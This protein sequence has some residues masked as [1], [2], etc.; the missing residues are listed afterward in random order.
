MA[1]VGAGL[2]AIGAPIARAE[3]SNNFQYPTSIASLPYSTHG[4]TTSATN[5]PTDPSSQCGAATKNV[6]FKYRAPTD[7][8]VHLT[9]T[10]GWAAV[11]A[12]YGLSPSG[13]VFRASPPTDWQAMG[14]ES[15]GLN[16]VEELSFAAAAGETYRIE[17]GGISP[18]FTFGEVQSFGPF[19]LEVSEVPRPLNDRVVDAAPLNDIPSSVTGTGYGATY[20][21]GEPMSSCTSINVPETLWYRYTETTGGDVIVTNEGSDYMAKLAVFTGPSRPVTEVACMVPGWQGRVSVS[22][23]AIAGTTYWMQLSR[24]EPNGGALATVAI[25]RA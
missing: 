8:M 18:N 5:D 13:K 9:L 15:E 16:S 25:R 17:V 23:T 11:L 21:L 12:V 22:F 20:E 7:Q 14:C 4:D 2:L 6:W 24:A 10:H 19:D 3:G 1:A